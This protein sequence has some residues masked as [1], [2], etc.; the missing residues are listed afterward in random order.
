MVDYGGLQSKGLDPGSFL[1]G[2]AESSDLEDIIKKYLVV[3]YSP[4]H[5]SRLAY[6]YKKDV[7][8]MLDNLSKLMALLVKAGMNPNWLI[9]AVSLAIQDVYVQRVAAKL[10][11]D[12]KKPDGKFKTTKTLLEEIQSKLE[13]PG[14]KTTELKIAKVYSEDYRNEVIHGGLDVDEDRALDIMRAT[15]NLID[16]LASI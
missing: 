12:I 4:G 14:I 13:K 5:A 3:H 15:S 1:K 7:A 8:E 9:A 2:L 6:H 11:I 10:K 16:I